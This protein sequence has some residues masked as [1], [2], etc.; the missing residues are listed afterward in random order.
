MRDAADEAEIERRAEET[1]EIVQYTGD[2]V[3]GHG[4]E[5][6][7]FDADGGV[8]NDGALVGLLAQIDVMIRGSR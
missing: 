8:A 7:A 1:A 6:T 5:F 3:S 2:I 4:P